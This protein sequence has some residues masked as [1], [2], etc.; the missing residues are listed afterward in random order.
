ME[1]GVSHARASVEVDAPPEK[2]WKVIANPRNLPMWDRHITKVEGAPTNGLSKGSSYT[3]S[4]RFMGV[5]AKVEAEVLEIDPPRYSK[6]RWFR[7][8]LRFQSST[9]CPVDT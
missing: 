9:L 3:T 7:S 4:I 1:A 8:R 2:V 6:I 5:G